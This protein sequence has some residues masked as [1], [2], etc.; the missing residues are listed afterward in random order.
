MS[1][2]VILQT[3]Q[4]LQMRTKRDRTNVKLFMQP[5]YDLMIRTGLIHEHVFKSKN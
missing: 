5:N 3:L 4:K 1:D 2:T